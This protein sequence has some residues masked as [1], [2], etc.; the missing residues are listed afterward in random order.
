MPSKKGVR[1]FSEIQKRRL[2]KLGIDEN[3]SPD[4]LT[5]DEVK[6][7]NSFSPTIGFPYIFL[8]CL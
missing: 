2:R 8:N 7:I 4:D 6:K 1:A 3:K 5:E